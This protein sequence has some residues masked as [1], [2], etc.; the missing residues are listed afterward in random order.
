MND[1]RRLMPE[2]G[3]HRLRLMPEDGGHRLRSSAA[4]S[5]IRDRGWTPSDQQS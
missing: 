4:A 3:G 2:D 5:V 1:E